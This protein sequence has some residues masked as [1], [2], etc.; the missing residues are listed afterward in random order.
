M[1]FQSTA[2]LASN[3]YTLFSFTFN[4]VP[5][6][7]AVFHKFTFLA[8]P[9]FPII[10]KFPSNMAY[11]PSDSLGRTGFHKDLPSLPIN[12]RVSSLNVNFSDLLP[13]I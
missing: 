8:F 1:A 5:P 3:I 7:T 12:Y 11:I 6:T 13:T 10:F 4:W 9:Y 2:P